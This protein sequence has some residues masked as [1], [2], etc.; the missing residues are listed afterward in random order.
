MVGSQSIRGSTI[1]RIR[2]PKGDMKE[3]F[4]K[5]VVRGS[6]PVEK[7]QTPPAREEKVK[8]GSFTE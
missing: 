7:C 5:E 4:V 6:H 3:S 2:E 8:N 1:D